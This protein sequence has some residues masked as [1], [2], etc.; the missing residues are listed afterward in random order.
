M[1]RVRTR[2]HAVALVCLLAGCKEATVAEPAASP[3]PAA[4]PE[5]APDPAASPEP[6]PASA[7]PDAAGASE[8]PASAPASYELQGNMLVLP[9]PVEF[10]AGS[11]QIAGEAA[12]E[13][14]RGY[15]AAKS[16][17]TTM[18]IEAHVSGPDAQA[19]SERRALAAARWLVSKGV[20][21]KRLLPVGFG[22]T[23]PIASEQTPEGRAQN[24]RVEAH[25][26]ALRERLIGGMP[27]DGGGKVAGDPCV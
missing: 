17:V 18:R 23:K 19:L 8:P 10:A 6:A 13:H 25:N 12:L 1:A 3:E 24:T 16:Y 7:S 9:R 14:I 4:P 15:L 26:A 20:D 2:F 27:A 22:A 5:P 11:D 21:C